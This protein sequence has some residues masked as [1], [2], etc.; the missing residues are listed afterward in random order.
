M[1]FCSILSILGTLTT[2][3][4]N[5][6]IS[7]AMILFYIDGMDASLTFYKDGLGLKTTS[8]SPGWSTLR[9]TDT[10]ELALHSHPADSTHQA[11]G[12]HPF[13]TGDT[14]LILNVDDLD[15]YCDRILATGGSVDRIIE[16]RDGIPVRMGLVFDPSHNGL[17]V[18]QY[19]G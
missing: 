4:E 8:E 7:G 18:N 3:E 19:V 12:K 1:Q 10:L 6:M 14:T 15:A 2:I 5:P 13:D 16:R 17:Q 11:S 9:V